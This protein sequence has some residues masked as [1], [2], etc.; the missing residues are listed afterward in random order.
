M[1]LTHPSLAN[2]YWVSPSNPE[3]FYNWVSQGRSHWMLSHFKVNLTNSYRVSLSNQIWNIKSVRYRDS[4]LKS[5]NSWIRVSPAK[6]Q[7]DSIRTQLL[8][9]SLLVTHQWVPESFHQKFAFG[10]NW[11]NKIMVYAMRNLKKTCS[12]VRT[13]VYEVDCNF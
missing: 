7:T 11:L 8:T 6:S 1:S 9:L 5:I 2:H 12:T 13:T 4:H 3:L 10:S